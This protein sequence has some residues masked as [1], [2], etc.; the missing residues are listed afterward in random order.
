MGVSR[1]YRIRDGGGGRLPEVSPRAPQ[2]LGPALV[3]A[4]LGDLKKFPVNA[5]LE[6]YKLKILPCAVHAIAEFSKRLTVEN[7][8][9]LDTIKAR[10]LKKCIGVAQNT[11]NTLVF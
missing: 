8:R 11:S 1:I 3:A 10:Y 9:S 7:M 4:L 6:I 5:A 2:T